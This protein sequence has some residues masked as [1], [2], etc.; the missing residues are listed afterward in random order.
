MPGFQDTV[1]GVSRM[2][3]TFTLV[4]SDNNSD[5][6]ESALPGSTVSR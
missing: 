3:D 5:F 6:G 2:R 1:N 4:R